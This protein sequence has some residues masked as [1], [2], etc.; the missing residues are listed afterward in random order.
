MVLTAMDIQSIG[1]AALEQGALEDRQEGVGVFGK[2]EG[3]VGH[4]A[5]G[6]V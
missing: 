6:V 5:R 1:D 3:G 4:E 2:G